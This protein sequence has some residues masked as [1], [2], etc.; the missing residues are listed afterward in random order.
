MNKQFIIFII[1][2]FFNFARAQEKPIIEWIDNNALNISN[3]NQTNDINI[4]FDRMSEKFKNARI[5]GFGEASHQHKDFFNLKTKFFKY[6]VINNNLKILFLEES[7]GGAYSANKYVKNGEGNPVEII[8]NFRQGFL[9]TSEMLSLIE[10]IKTYNESQTIQNQI[11][12]YGMDCMFNYNIVSILESIFQENNFE[13]KSNILELFKKY[14]VEKFE[15]YKI[16]EITA[17]ISQIQSVQDS[18]KNI[19]LFKN[20]QDALNGLEALKSY[21]T[22]MN[23]PTQNIRDKNMADLIFY[24][25]DFKKAFISAHNYHIQKTELPPITSIPSLG[26]WLEKKIG[27]KY[28]SVGFDFGVGKVKG[29]NKD[30]KWEEAEINTVTKNTFTET[31]FKS[32]KAI[33]YFDFS[34]AIKDE[35]MNNFLTKNNYYLGIGGYGILPR[36][37]KY[38]L[39][40]GKLFEMYDALIFVKKVTL[41]SLLK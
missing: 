30:K 36:Q 4:P 37:I 29:Y 31:F 41:N 26:N 12:I 20:K 40:K 5:Y 13:L 1:L 28:Y 14:K 38:A 2:I 9:H 39:I 3:S 7:F 8:K 18:I 21:I 24:A 35:K 6:L 25:S 17:E 32:S 19:S 15:P 33:F 11:Q 34:E 23:E 16:K 22:F 27:L 10:W